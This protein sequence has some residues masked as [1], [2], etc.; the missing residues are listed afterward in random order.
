MSEI[1]IFLRGARD[2]CFSGHTQIPFAMTAPRTREPRYPAATDAP[3]M[4]DPV[5]SVRI[6][7][8][9]VPFVAVGFEAKANKKDEGIRFSQLQYQ[10]T[11]Y[12]L[13][14]WRTRTTWVGAV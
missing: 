4:M 6:S 1:E 2:H 14:G 5:A 8:G 12:L 13:S 10:H 9:L 3:E 11:H 7:S